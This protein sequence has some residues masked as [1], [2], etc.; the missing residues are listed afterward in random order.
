MSAGRERRT[1]K[2]Q[3]YRNRA[4]ECRVQAAEL[5]D[6]DARAGLIQVAQSYETMARILAAKILDD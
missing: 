4:E 1:E 6:P 5:H 3:R 2:I